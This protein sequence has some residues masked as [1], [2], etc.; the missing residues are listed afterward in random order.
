MKKFL[1]L[2]GIGF[3]AGIVVTDI[4]MAIFIGAQSVVP[5]L[6]EKAGGETAAVFLQMMLSGFYGAVCFGTTVLYDADRLPMSLVSF[7]HCLIC[8]V[9]FIFISRLLGWSQDLA[10][11]LITAGA[12]VLAYFIIWLIMYARNKK[13]I[14]ELNRINDRSL[15][16]SE[17]EEK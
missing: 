6:I 15:S 1:K 17:T 8:I 10:R 11:T 14:T 7:L 4:M 16:H 2:A 3:L 12:Q 9:P 13:A 5:E